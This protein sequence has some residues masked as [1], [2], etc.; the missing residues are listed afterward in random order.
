MQIFE[1]LLLHPFPSIALMLKVFLAYCK[2]KPL[3]L[4]GKERD[5]EALPQWLYED[6]QR[7]PI[8]KGLLCWVSVA[9]LT[10]QRW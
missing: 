1:P 9:I 3:C 6:R 4:V 8:Y 5:L 2:R 10:I 7:R